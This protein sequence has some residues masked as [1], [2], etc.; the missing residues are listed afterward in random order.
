MQSHRISRRSAMLAGAAAALALLPANGWG[1]TS[2]FGGFQL[3][4]TTFANGQFLPISMIDNIV[5]NGVNAC[6]IN[7]APGGDQSP[8]LSWTGVPAGTRSFVVTL[9]DVT[10]SFTHWGMYNIAGQRAGLPEDAGIAGSAFGMQILND[11]GSSSRY[12]GPCPPATVAPYVHDYVFTVYALNTELTLPASANF[13]A[14][15][16]TLYQALIAAGRQGHILA[17]ASLFGVY[18]THTGPAAAGNEP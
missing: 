9:Y 4:S 14:N 2:A 3:S 6:S 15:A 13:P 17:S 16:E 7:G 18:S 11:F 1:Q 5:S 12:D 8:E 10:A